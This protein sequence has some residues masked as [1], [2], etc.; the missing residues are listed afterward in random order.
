MKSIGGFEVADAIADPN[1][2]FSDPSEVVALEGVCD[3]D[4]LA[5]L[6]SWK[7]LVSQADDPGLTIKEIDLALDQIK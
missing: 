4:K 1:S 5:I 3:H 2:I 7:A 6:K